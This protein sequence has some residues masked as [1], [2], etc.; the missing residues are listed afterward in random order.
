MEKYI[1]SQFAAINELFE[2][3]KGE[4]ADFLDRAQ[5]TVVPSIA[6]D[7]ISAPDA[8][9]W[10][11]LASIFS[12]KVPT[13]AIERIPEDD[14]ARIASWRR[15]AQTTEHALERACYQALVETGEAIFAV[16]G[17]LTRDRRLVSSI[18]LRLVGN[19]YGTFAIGEFLAPFFS[20][21]ARSEGFRLLP[22]QSHPLV[23]NVKGASASGKS[24]MRPLQ[25][26]LAARLGV[27]WE[28]FA[29]FS[30]DIWR[31]YLLDYDSLGPARKYAGTLTGTEVAIID[32][33]LDR[34][35]AY[36]GKIGE[37]PHLLIDRFRF[38]SF[39]PDE[40]DGSRLLTRFGTEVFMFFMITPPEATIE[41][42]WTRGL[43]FGRYKAVDDL[44]AHNVEAYSGIP[45]LFFTWALRQD[46]RVH[47]E[48]LD[49]S[50]AEGQR[51]RTVAFG[52]NGQMHIL[53]L[54]CLL[55]IDRYRNINVDAQTPAAIYASPSSRC[56]AKNPEILKQCIRRIPTVVF[57]EQKTGNVY[58][59]IA[60][61][62]LVSWNRK[63][64]EAA[65]RDDDT[66]SAFESV[67]R[68]P[69]EDSSQSVSRRLDPHENLTLGRWGET[70]G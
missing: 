1:A 7:R 2:R 19:D 65:V 18:A 20:K 46:K 29:L 9:R 8:G 14:L 60:N 39:E 52:L 47:F 37:L 70:R 33:K 55:D 5:E 40:E 31:K 32:Q 54:T 56:V 11:K 4:A 53:D 28:D 36:K 35:M 45:G 44:L 21:A 26:Q 48:F 50:V 10:S 57:A 41:R 34:Y 64:Y 49:N 15:K 30:P 67:A 66:R 25:K 63:V 68:P 17:Q 59:E 62:K 22:A 23:M 38:D 69:R 51:P 13:Q 24:T 42:A 61:G 58:A 3:L 27:N 12:R 16:H 6:P 43:Q